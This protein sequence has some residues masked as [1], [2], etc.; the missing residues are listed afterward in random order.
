MHIEELLKLHKD[1]CDKTREIM[2]RK[3]SDYT[4]GSQAEDALANFKSA[5]MLGLHPVT[6][7]LLRVQD[8]LMRIRSFIAD[9]QL[10]VSGETVEDACDDLV[11]YSILAK[12]LL[13]EEYMQKTF[14]EKE[15]DAGQLPAVSIPHT[16]SETANMTPDHSERAHAEFSPSALKLLSICAGF[17]GKDADNEASLRGTR[18][19]EALEIENPS[20]LH[21]EEEVAIYELILAERNHLLSIMFGDELPE[22]FLNEIRLTIE[23]DAATPCFG[24]CDFLAFREGANHALMIDYKTGISKIDPPQENMQAK[25]YALGAFQKYSHLD[26]IQFAF[27]VPRNGGTLLGTFERSRMAELRA[28]LSEVVRRAETTRPKW[29]TGQ[30]DIDDCTP[31]VNCRF[32]RHEDRCPALGGLCLSVA[33]RYRPDLLPDGDISSGAVEDPATLEKLFV[34]AKIVENWASGIKH[35]AMQL[36]LSGHEYDTLRLK[37]MGT[38]KKV[39]ENSYFLKLAEQHGLDRDEVLKLAEFSLTKVTDLIGAQAPRGKK[40]AATEAFINEAL[41]HGIIEPGTERFTLTQKK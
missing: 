35:K 24:T 2:R 20:A 22:N 39:V 28:E 38:P 30:I 3:N 40:G 5:R 34:I 41:E 33:K 14:F 6:G 18:I 19:H 26:T 37:S 9:G 10:A 36:A 11:N 12:A 31:S 8:K 16:K 23:L 25:A 17:H 1:T 13:R 32:C 27:I 7:L 4:G 21:D 29:E 15:V